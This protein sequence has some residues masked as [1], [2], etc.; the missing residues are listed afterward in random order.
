MGV[1]EEILR[2]LRELH[3]KVDRLLTVPHSSGGATVADDRDLDSQWG[4][5]EIKKDPKRWDGASHVGKRMSECD[6]AF[7]DAYAEFKDWAANMDEK[8][9]KEASGDEAEKK[10]K[11]ARYGRKTAARARGWSARLRSGWKPPEKPATGFEEGW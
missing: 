11:Y 4:D 10:E 7:L 9:A 2:E 8:K 5:E 6:P 3:A 1:G